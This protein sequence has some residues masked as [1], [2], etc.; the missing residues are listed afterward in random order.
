MDQKMCKF[1][2]DE[3]IMKETITTIKVLIVENKKMKKRWVE[4]E[5]TSY[6]LVN[7]VLEQTNFQIKK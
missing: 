6:Y 3:A 7:Q 4:K 2:N 5:I 1:A